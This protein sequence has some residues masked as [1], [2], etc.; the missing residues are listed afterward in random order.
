MQILECFSGDI[1]KTLVFLNG[2]SNNIEHDGNTANMMDF[3]T[4]I[5]AIKS[6][7]ASVGASEISS[8][9][10]RLETAGNEND[11]DFIRQALPDFNSR[12]AKLARDISQRTAGD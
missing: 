11:L 4:N 2:F 6:A 12:L 1:G 10:A 9:A 5:H 8:Q 7:A 3:T